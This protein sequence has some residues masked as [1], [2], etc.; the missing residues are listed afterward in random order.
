MFSL[1]LPFLLFPQTREIPL[2]LNL[3]QGL[4]AHFSLDVRIKNRNYTLDLFKHSRRSENFILKTSAG[5]I[6]A[7][8]SKT[9]VGTVH[10]FPGAR[11]A[12][13]LQKNGLFARIQFPDETSWWRIRPNKNLERGVHTLQREKPDPNAK[14]GTV[15]VDLENKSGNQSTQGPPTQTGTPGHGQPSMAPA[16]WEN[17]TVREAQVAYDADHCYYN[18]HGGSTITG[19]LDSVEQQLSELELCYVQ[20]AMATY[21][22]TGV[23]IRDQPYYTFTSAGDALGKFSRDWDSN[24]WDIPRD[25]A[26]LLTEY[27]NDGIAGL[28][29]VGTL[30]GW[31]YG[32]TV[33]NSGWSPGIMAHE[34]GHNWGAGH[35]DCWPWGGSAMCGAWLL[36]GPDTSNIVK[37]RANW[38]N[39]PIQPAYFL[40]AR[41]YADPDYADAVAGE[42]VLLDVLANDHDGNLDPLHFDTWDAVGD[43]NGTIA[44]SVGT[45]PG[46]RDELTYTPDLTLTGGYTETFWYTNSDPGGLT[47]NTPVTINVRPKQRVVHWEFQEQAGDITADGTGLGNFGEIGRDP[48]YA[49][50]A[51]PTITDSANAYSTSYIA[52]HLFDGNPSTE[53]SSASQGPVTSWLSNNPSHGTW[54]EF[55]FGTTVDID[56]FRHQDRAENA[57]WTGNSRL[58]FSDDT[59][60]TASD[61]VV[62][63][64]HYDPGRTA[65]YGFERQS[66]RYVR[67]E[68]TAPWDWNNTTQ[69]LGGAEAAFLVQADLLPLD[70]P[71]VTLSS[72]TYGGYIAENLVDGDLNTEFISNN[73]GVTT[74]SLT[75]DP[76]HGTWLE[77][78]FGST[79]SLDGIRFLD[80][81]MQLG[82]IGTSRLIFSQD[83][84]FDAT[85]PQTRIT[86]FNPLSENTYSF[87]SQTCRYI[88]WEI[89]SLMDPGSTYKL[90]GGRE[91][92][93]LTDN[94]STPGYQ[95]VM[96]GFDGA[97]ELLGTDAVRNRSAVGIPTDWNAPFTL[98]LH[99]WLDQAQ[100]NKTLIAGIGDPRTDTNNL[101]FFHVN[102]GHL[103]FG[104]FESSQALD[105]QQ[106]Q[107]ISATYDGRRLRL[108]QN[109]N[110]VGGWEWS[111]NSASS[112]AWIAPPLGPQGPSQLSARVDEFSVHDWN[113]SPQEILD[114][115]AG[116][117]ASGPQPMD[118]ARSVS[119][120]TVLRWNAG[121]NQPKQDIYLGT[122]FHAVQ[123]ADRN[124]PEYIGLANSPYLN[125]GGLPELTML[126]WRADQVYTGFGI[127]GPVWRFKTEKDWTSAIVESFEDGIAGDHLSG[128]GLGSGFADSWSAHGGNGF[129]KRDGSINPFPSNLPLVEAGGYLESPQ[130]SALDRTAE[131]LLDIASVDIDLGGG[132]TYY[133]SFAVKAEGNG[134]EPTAMIGLRDSMT[135][136][137]F[138]AGSRNGVWTAEG[139]TG[140]ASAG[141]FPRYKSTFVVLKVECSV[142]GSDMLSLKAYDVASENVHPSDALLAGMGTDQNQWTLIT[143]GGT[144]S[145]RANQLTMTLGAPSIFFNAFIKMDEI[146]VGRTWKDVTG[147]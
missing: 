138:A 39:L 117:K 59:I 94:A 41:P 76:S 74:N 61:A 133:L 45:G 135:G 80:R 131:R 116:G 10:G 97:L 91:L 121:L 25:T 20:D 128:L 65:D 53:Y 113:F 137:S 67:W 75:T 95:W 15:E 77:M 2:S 18:V 112:Q 89:T 132:S 47:H 26:Y 126:Y 38:L 143:N 78:D 42:T 71:L 82:W 104:P 63:L 6:P 64:Q 72:N 96:D 115:F 68:I 51:S 129:T 114:Q 9:Y 40:P 30:G 24:H 105:I 11:V 69:N 55:D 73:Q 21:E 90:I 147:L 36:L 16:G 27:Q 98:N 81:S 100:A 31:S 87:S 139:V 7:P 44:L 37:N 33:W 17:W 127:R 66:A 107:M 49:T 120:D 142:G 3:P 84:V 83:N 144:S 110:K 54:I 140:G 32:E 29:Y 119:V 23:V 34:I 8:E 5:I 123:N 136:E 14:C 130:N 103:A 92:T 43:R 102:N 56:G 85:D 111:P 124:S 108:Y 13:S 99:L 62:D 145:M 60:F 46:G 146:R 122:D 35:I 88:R 52:D 86:H 134:P 109:A 19:T 70:P 57:D 48:S 118:G 79:V 58:I 101:R 4:P 22:L 28:A 12:A 50:L 125:P 106:W 141:N 93:F 1:I